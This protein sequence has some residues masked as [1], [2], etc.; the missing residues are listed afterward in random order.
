M[1]EVLY[2]RNRESLAGANIWLMNPFLKM[3]FVMQNHLNINEFKWIQVGQWLKF[4][5]V[6]ILDWYILY[7]SH[8]PYHPVRF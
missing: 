3:D 7:I 5:E 6:D 1:C 2:T 8:Q 4:S